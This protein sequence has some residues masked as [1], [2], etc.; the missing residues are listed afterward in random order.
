MNSCIS[1]NTL[2]FHIIENPYNLLNLRFLLE[3]GF[4]Q[5]QKFANIPTRTKGNR[6]I[7]NLSNS[8]V[9]KNKI[10]PIVLSNS[11]GNLEN[12]S[13]HRTVEPYVNLSNSLSA[14]IHTVKYQNI[15]VGYHYNFYDNQHIQH[16][17]QM[18][19]SKTIGMNH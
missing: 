3:S 8:P 5:P 9:E 12:L 18:E 14:H 16:I 15:R 7:T 13:N 10:C 4:P 19:H 17:I 11:P 6:H 2:G 1:E